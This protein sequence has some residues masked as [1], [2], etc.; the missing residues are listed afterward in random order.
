MIYPCHHDEVKW[1]SRGYGSLWYP[2]I[3][4]VLVSAV[5]NSKGPCRHHGR[6][7]DRFCRTDRTCICTM[8]ADTDHRDHRIVPLSKEAAR[9]KA[10]LNKQLFKLTRAIQERTLR[11]E[12]TRR[13]L[14][15]PTRRPGGDLVEAKGLEEAGGLGEAEGLLR[16]QEQETLDLQQRKTDLE[17]LSQM[18]D[19]LSF[20][21][22][23]LQ[24]CSP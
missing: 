17:E 16:D 12:N 15:L 19:P 6:S 13:S 2:E 14:T 11:A 4:G 10:K 8:C 18:A 1:L 23:S 20:L 9:A 7:V 5:K 24:K 22:K 21:L 3:S